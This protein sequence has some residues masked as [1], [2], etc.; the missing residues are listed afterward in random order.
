[1][2]ITQFFVR[3]KFCVFIYGIPDMYICIYID[4]N[5]CICLSDYMLLHVLKYG[6]QWNDD[7]FMLVGGNLNHFRWICFDCGRCYNSAI[8][9]QTTPAWLP[10]NE[11]ETT[12][13]GIQTRKQKVSP[14]QKTKSKS[15]SHQ[16]QVSMCLISQRINNAMLK[17][18]RKLWNF[19]WN[20]V[21]TPM[22]NYKL[23]IIWRATDG[24]LH[25][26]IIDQG[27]IHCN[28]TI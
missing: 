12:S 27:Y 9:E 17:V 20:Q 28:I 1:M 4:E 22:T 25:L 2:S 16:G 3:D 11:I 14:A 15:S 8:H 26:V 5:M 6:N 21:L 23:Q 13:K 24:E 10:T 18:I 19:V 7:L